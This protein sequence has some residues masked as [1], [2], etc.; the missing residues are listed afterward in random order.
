MKVADFYVTE[1]DMRKI[2]ALDRN[3]RKIEP[4]KKLK[5][6]KIVI[7]DCNSKFYPFY[8]IETEE[9]LLD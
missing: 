1:S 2:A 3:L 8:H 4:V 5:N 6:G 9:C 7:R